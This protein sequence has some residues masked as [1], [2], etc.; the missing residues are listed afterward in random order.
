MTAGEKLQAWREAKGLS[1]AKFAAQCGLNRSLILKY[2]DGK[3][4]PSVAGRM[5][6]ETETGGAIKRGDWGG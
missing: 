6:I 1:R 5:L 2:E 3:V 4:T